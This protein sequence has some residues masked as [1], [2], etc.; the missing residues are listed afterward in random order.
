MKENVVKGLVTLALASVW[1]Y[2][3]ELAAPLAVLVAVMVMDYVTG[4]AEAWAGGTLSSR[5]GIMGIVKKLG[6]LFGVSVAV[7]ADWVIQTAGE[8]A[9]MALDGF[10][11][12]GLLVTVWMI[13]NECISILE[14]I[15][16]L[17]VPLPGFLVKLVGRLKKTAEE[18]GEGVSQ[19]KEED[20]K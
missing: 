8:K 7:V 2:F 5:V 17:G 14:N 11:M 15:S 6:Y 19:G 4:M 3:R 10:Y 18:R 13:L 12:F 20:L 1:A 16:Q 9:G